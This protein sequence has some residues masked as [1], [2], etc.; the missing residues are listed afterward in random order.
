MDDKQIEKILKAL[1]WIFMVF[2]ILY[3]VSGVSLFNDCFTVQGCSLDS[4]LL[5]GVYIPSG[6]STIFLTN[7]LGDVWILQLASSAI[8]WGIV[9]FIKGYILSFLIAYVRKAKRKK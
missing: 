3:G 8:L 9:G 6:V 4:N 1:P 5:F 7:L 2:G